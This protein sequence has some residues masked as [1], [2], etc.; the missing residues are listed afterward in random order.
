MYETFCAF[1]PDLSNP[2]QYGGRDLRPARSKFDA[3]AADFQKFRKEMR[4]IRLCNQSGVTE[5]QIPG[6]VIAKNLGKRCTMAYDAREYP[7][8][9]WN[10]HLTYK[11]LRRIPKFSGEVPTVNEENDI[12]REEVAVSEEIGSSSATRRDSDVNVDNDQS[13]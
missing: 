10:N 9:L 8:E 13:D 2:K 7:H 1:A 11:V 5:D 4:L 6:M 3:V 12:G